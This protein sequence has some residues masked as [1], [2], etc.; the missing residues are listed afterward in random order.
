F[1]FDDM[2][3][4]V[5]GLSLIVTHGTHWVRYEQDGTVVE[6]DAAAVADGIVLAEVA[7][8]LAVP[9]ATAAAPAQLG[10]ITRDGVTVVLPAGFPAGGASVV[11]AAV[12]DGDSFLSNA[13][14]VTVP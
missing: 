13:L 14:T 7:S 4:D 10:G 8:L 12:F 9:G 11:L 5:F 2:V 1:S 6:G 3:E